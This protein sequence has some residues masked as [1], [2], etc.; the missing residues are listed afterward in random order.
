MD[1]VLASL[2]AD[3]RDHANELGLRDRTLDVRMRLVG[4]PDQLQAIRELIF[5]DLGEGS[6]SAKLVSVLGGSSSETPQRELL[7]VVSIRPD[8]D[9]APSMSFVS[10]PG[11]TGVVPISL[12]A[13]APRTGEL[14]H[15]KLPLEVRANIQ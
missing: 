9:G 10:R 7:V 8:I 13:I 6:L 3:M 4:D 2:E 15:L 12:Q 1:L 11:T 5:S 14:V